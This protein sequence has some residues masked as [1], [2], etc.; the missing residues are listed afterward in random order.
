MEPINLY[1]LYR[2]VKQRARPERAAKSQPTQKKAVAM[3]LAADRILKEPTLE[4]VEAFRVAEKSW[5]NS[6]DVS[7][8]A[9]CIADKFEEAI[10]SNN[11]IS[12]RSHFDP[13]GINANRQSGLVYCAQS[14]SM[15]GQM[16]LGFTTMDL[17]LRLQ[18]FSGR[19]EVPDVRPLFAIRVGYPAEVERY[20][21][22]KLRD[23]LVSGC[24][25]GKSNEW[26]RTTAI[27]IARTLVDT[28]DECG[29]EV[30]EITLYGACPNADNV[31][32]ALRRL[33]LP[34]GRKAWL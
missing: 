31:S 5:F 32:A 7:S 21:K 2:T 25:L 19:Y 8:S 28:L 27:D 15:P 16:K 33:G 17:G 10:L 26:Y 18:K 30:S 23:A 34:V 1:D 12:E 4:R 6:P 9:R 3:C 22:S 24:T 13:R 29:N 14:S 20:A 11:F